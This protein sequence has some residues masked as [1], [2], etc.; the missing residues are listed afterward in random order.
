MSYTLTDI[1]KWY[2]EN[3][4]H[5]S[6]IDEKLFRAIWS[7]YINESIDKIVLEGG[8]ITLLGRMGELMV[9]RRN[10]NASR[11]TPNWG[12]TNKLKKE[13]GFKGVVYFTDSHYCAYLWRKS[14]CFIKNKSI[15]HFKPTRGAKGLKTRLIDKLKN[16]E[17]AYLNF[18]KHANL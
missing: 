11:P 6:E 2:E 5:S 14:K 16:D 10:R 13:E 3:K 18:K 9:V 1:Y 8:Y 15:W 4:K 7:D 17:F 12:E